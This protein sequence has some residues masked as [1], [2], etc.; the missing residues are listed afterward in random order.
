[1]AARL[2]VAKLP[3]TCGNLF[4][5]WLTKLVGKPILSLSRLA[6]YSLMA[7]IIKR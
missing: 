7:L 1:M 4:G 6:G 3:E 5:K 2:A